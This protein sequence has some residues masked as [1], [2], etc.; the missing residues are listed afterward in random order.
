MKQFIKLASFLLFFS[1]AC[2]NADQE[3]AKAPEDDLDAVRSFIRAALDGD[4]ETGRKLLVSDSVNLRY[5]N[6]FEEIYN[7][8]PPDEKQRFKSATI[9]IHDFRHVND[10]LTVVIYSNS[11]KKEHD[12]LTVLRVQGQWLVDMTP[13]DNSILFQQPD[14]LN[15]NKK[16]SLQ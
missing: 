16:D 13:W 3:S 7:T 12:T 11:Y 14:S 2:N 1:Y 8:I 4:H 10:S 15:N 9:N 6:Y 5:Y